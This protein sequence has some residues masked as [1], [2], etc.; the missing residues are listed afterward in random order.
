MKLRTLLQKAEFFYLKLVT[1]NRPMCLNVTIE[2]TLVLTKGG[3]VSGCTF[4][5]PPHTKKAGL[6]SAA[7][8]IAKNKPHLYV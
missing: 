4:L 2:G 3:Y 7:S 8:S 1:F 5:P 6:W